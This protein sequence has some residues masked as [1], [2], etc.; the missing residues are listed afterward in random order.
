MKAGKLVSIGG[1]KIL[2]QEVIPELGSDKGHSYLGI[3][4]DNNIIHIEMKSK[5]EKECYKR[6]R[7][8]ISSKLNGGNTF[9]GQTPGQ[10]P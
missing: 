8:L 9:R 1:V 3:L 6:M 5:I 4:Q 2:F 10:Y 7:Q